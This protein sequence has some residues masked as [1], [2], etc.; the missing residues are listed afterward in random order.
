MNRRSKVLVAAIVVALAQI[1][2][3]SSA[4]YSRAALLRNGEEVTLR[5]VPVDPHD[6]LRGDYVALSYDISRIPVDRV[7]TSRPRDNDVVGAVYVRLKRGENHAPAQIVGVGL[8]APLDEPLGANEIDLNGTSFD[9]WQT[10]LETLNIRYG[11]ERFYVPEGEGR[12]IER[13]LGE[14]SFTIRVAV[15]KEGDAQ[16]KALYDGDVALYSEPLY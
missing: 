15:G 3:L 12:A 13:R 7:R 16:I 4:I 14:R 9:R 11:L 2:F 10:G 5:T 1:G 8:G 6:L